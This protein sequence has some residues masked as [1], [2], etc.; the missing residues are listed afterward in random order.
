M[1]YPV[2]S[3][4]QKDAPFI[5]LNLHASTDA[6]ESDADKDHLLHIDTRLNTKCWLVHLFEY[7]VQVE[8]LLLI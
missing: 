4:D 5:R 8:I 7:D 6:L 1:R 3:I 2:M